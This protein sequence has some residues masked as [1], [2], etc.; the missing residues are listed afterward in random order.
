MHRIYANMEA[1]FAKLITDP[2]KCAGGR[3]GDKHD[4]LWS[5]VDKFSRFLADIF[6]KVKPFSVA[7]GHRPEVW[8]TTPKDLIPY[9]MKSRKSVATE[10]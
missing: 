9:G 10:I 6:R 1:S 3:F 5:V 8:P 4:V 2:S 7:R